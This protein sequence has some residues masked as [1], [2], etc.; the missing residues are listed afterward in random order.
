MVQL[1][2]HRPHVR[3]LLALGLPLVGGQIAQVSIQ[4]VDTLML[5]WYDPRVLAGVALANSIFFALFIV[6]AGFSWAVTPMVAAAAAKHDQTRIRRVTRMGFWIS[7]GYAAA[8]MPVL[9]NG[10][11]LLRLL[12]QEP[13]LADLAQ[14]YLRVAAW[15]LF[16]MLTIMLMRSYLAGQS[17][18]RVVMWV[19]LAGMVVN[20]LFNWLLI[21]GNLGFPELGGPGA[22]LASVITNL[23]GVAALAAYARRAFPEAQLFV[24]IWRPDWEELKQVFQLGWPIGMATLAETALFSA[25][26]VMIGWIGVAELAAHAIAIQIATLTFMLHVG[27]AQA[28]TVL[29]G[30]AWARGDLEEQRGLARTALAVTVVLA[31]ATVAVLVPLRAPLVLFFLDPADPLRDAVLATGTGLVVMAALFQFADGAQVVMISLLRGVQDTRVP[32]W[33]AAVSYWGIGAPLGFV[34]GFPA[35]FGAVGVWVGLAGGL[36]CAAVLLG[37]R[38]WRVKLAEG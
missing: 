8:S 18:T 38:L 28:A 19:T 25:T 37:Q 5:G 4:I 27:M 12:G 9:L 29:M 34:L 36:S 6:G 1:A 7:M 30:G 17:R 15:G 11:A 20:A 13:E 2:D 16:P 35:G 26:A 32:M 14:D 10:G 21:F 24:R 31:T 23:C 33:L 22:A 3:S